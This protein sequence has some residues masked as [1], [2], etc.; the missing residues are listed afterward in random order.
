M[1]SFTFW[2]LCQLIFG[3]ST[4][5][6]AIIPQTAILRDVIVSQTRSCFPAQGNSMA[7]PDLTSLILGM[8]DDMCESDSLFESYMFSKAERKTVISFP[9]VASSPITTHIGWWT[10]ALVEGD[11]R[12]WTH[13]DCLQES[14]MIV[15]GCAT[16]S[17]KS[18]L[19]HGGNLTT[20]WVDGSAV[21]LMIELDVPEI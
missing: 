19:K 10:V 3:T 4:T 11:S 12:L 5:L 7:Q 20:T 9:I 17:G 14:F 2:S 21:E 1:V 8:C 18:L 13:G 16:S 6:G 15:N